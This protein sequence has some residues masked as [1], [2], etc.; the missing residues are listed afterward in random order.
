MYYWDNIHYTYQ[1]IWL[2]W[3]VA[4]SLT[5]SGQQMIVRFFLVNFGSCF[6]QVGGHYWFQT[7]YCITIQGNVSTYWPNIC[8]H[9]RRQADRSGRT[10]HSS[11]SAPLLSNGILKERHRSR[12]TWWHTPSR[13]VLVTFELDQARA[14]L[15]QRDSSLRDLRLEWVGHWALPMQGHGS[16]LT[17]ANS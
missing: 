17:T 3:L 9:F 11:L 10:L 14:P 12:W 4:N 1:R 8:T 2:F 13:T 15:E 5:Q 16:C 7:S 6:Y